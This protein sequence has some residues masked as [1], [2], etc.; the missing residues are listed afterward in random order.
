MANIFWALERFLLNNAPAVARSTARGMV[1]DAAKKGVSWKGLKEVVQTAFAGVLS[2]T[3][4]ANFVSAVFGKQLEKT[5]LKG[6]DGGGVRTACRV[7][8]TIEVGS[9]TARIGVWAL[10]AKTLGLAFSGPVGW[11][12]FGV[13]LTVTAAGVVYDKSSIFHGWVNSLAA[14]VGFHLDAQ[15]SAPSPAIETHRALPPPTPPL[16]ARRRTLLSLS[17]V[18]GE[19]LRHPLSSR[20]LAR[21]AI[22]VKVRGI[23][24]Y[25]NFSHQQTLNGKFSG[26]AFSLVCG[27]KPA[28]RAGAGLPTKSHRISMVYDL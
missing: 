16:Q 28:K 2:I 10:G 27:G 3:P 1:T 23:P 5:G 11:T 17:P 18:A 22:N 26:A 24:V 25:C 7:N 4:I 12:T 13:T 20:H 8:A 21:K 9:I 15:P 19:V 6:H 14:H